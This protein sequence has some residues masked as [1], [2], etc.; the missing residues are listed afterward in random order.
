MFSIAYSN[1]EKLHRVQLDKENGKD[2]ASP[3]LIPLLI[4]SPNH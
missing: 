1:A 3:T 2:K 4:I